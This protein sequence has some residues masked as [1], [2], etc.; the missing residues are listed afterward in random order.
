MSNDHQSIN[1]THLTW[2]YRPVSHRICISVLY[3]LKLDMKRKFT[4]SDFTTICDKQEKS[5]SFIV[6]YRTEKSKHYIMNTVMNEIGLAVA[7]SGKR[8]QIEVTLQE[9][10]FDQR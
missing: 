1:Q 5:V 2:L 8:Q 10:H 4:M 3:C 9:L 6:A 7:Q